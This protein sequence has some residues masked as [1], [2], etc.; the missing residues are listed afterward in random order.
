[1]VITKINAQEWLEKEYPKNGICLGE[2]D[3]VYRINEKNKGKKRGEV[4]KLIFNIDP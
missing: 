4:T 1:M 3:K 2:F